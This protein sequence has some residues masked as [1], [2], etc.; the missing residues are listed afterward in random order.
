MISSSLFLNNF[1]ISSPVSIINHLLPGVH[2]PVRGNDRKVVQKDCKEAWEGEG[3]I[4]CHP[5]SNPGSAISSQTF[6]S[7]H[8]AADPVWWSLGWQWTVGEGFPSPQ[9]QS[10]IGSGLTKP[11]PPSIHQQFGIETNER[12]KE[13][14]LTDPKL[15][16]D[17]QWIIKRLI[18]MWIHCPSF[19]FTNRSNFLE[20]EM[21]SCH[22]YLRDTKEGTAGFSFLYRKY[23]VGKGK[24]RQR[25]IN[26]LL[27]PGRH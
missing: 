6:L 17:G 16:M 10:L 5:S 7:S 14:E 27:L 15:L 24:V 9:I 19:P 13:T 21:K 20:Q 23:T 18:Q 2:K 11:S 3:I 25:I 8:S 4:H 1:I 12:K 22:K 26:M